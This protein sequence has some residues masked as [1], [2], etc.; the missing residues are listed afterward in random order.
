MKHLPKTR[1]QN[2][3]TR[4]LG[5]ELLIYDELRHRAYCLNRTAA[6]VW[7]QC[8]G[9]RSIR[10]ISVLLGNE[11]TGDRSM[12][13]D[14]RLIWHAIKQFKRDQLL[15]EAI[16]IPQSMLA[17]VN[18]NPNRRQV[19]RALG[20]TAIVAVPLVSSIVAPRA[21]QASTCIASGGACISGPQC[22][23]PRICNSNVCV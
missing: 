12:P 2:L 16:E 11:L 22:C 21:V 1:K 10:Q 18:G 17:H 15:E 14:E 23:P 7:K 6:A 4:D 5:Y 13:I 3:I 8:N 9:K 20:L 19:I